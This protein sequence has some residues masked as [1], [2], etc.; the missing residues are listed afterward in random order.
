[1]DTYVWG[2]VDIVWSI[3]FI[4]IVLYLMFWAYL[5]FTNQ[6]P[7]IKKRDVEGTSAGAGTGLGGLKNDEE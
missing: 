1:M 6:R 3:I 7:F 4:V 2:Q 5:V